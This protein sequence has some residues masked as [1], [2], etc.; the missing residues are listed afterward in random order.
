LAT[1]KRDIDKGE[2]SGPSE[3]RGKPAG[4][5]YFLVIAIDTYQFG[6]SNQ[7]ERTKS[8]VANLNNPVR[9]ASRI[10]DVLTGEYTFNPSDKNEGVAVTDLRKTDTQYANEK[11]PIP[12]YKDDDYRRTCLYNGEATAQEVIDMIGKISGKIGK[13][14]ALLIY[15]AGHGVRVKDDNEYYLLCADSD[16][17]RSITWLNV[18]RLYSAFNNYSNQNRCRDLLMVIDACFSGAST[19]GFSNA[20]DMNV[21]RLVW[22]STLKDQLADDGPP[23]HGSGFANAFESYLRENSSPFLKV[24]N[25][26]DQLQSK[27]DAS[28]EKLDD[29]ETFWGFLPGEYGDGFFVFERRE[30]GKPKPKDLKD[31]FIDYLNFDAHRYSLTRRYKD[32][33]NCLNIITTHGYSYDIQKVASKITFRWLKKAADMKFEPE[34]C[35]RLDRLTLDNNPDDLWS[36]LYR[37]L[38]EQNDTLLNTKES[39]HNYL[40]DRLLPEEDQY[41]GK[42]HAIMWFYFSRGGEE[43]AKRIRTFCDEFSTLFLSKW[44][45]LA[46]ENKKNLGKMFILFLD[47]RKGVNPLKYEDFEELQN[48]KKINLITTDSFENITSNDVKIWQQK[49]AEENKST[50]IQNL[51]DFNNVMKMMSKDCRDFE[52]TY[53]EFIEKLCIYCEYTNTEKEL[54]IEYLF[55]FKTSLI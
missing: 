16:P 46:E 14:D 42:K 32:A 51:T 17:T 50:K 52:C 18:N 45:R 19:F 43:N 36:I 9:D 27:F 25:I 24:R 41:Y 3:T 40:F 23:E 12:V 10:V 44:E 30:K 11:I 5:Y 39:I 1:T 28:P 13:E 47:E 31:S 53:E 37:Q 2:D 4:N 26:P 22:S 54:L 15:F 29:Q 38:K 34:V 7:L 55:D 21:S 33:R 48:I 35:F 6:Y 49:A 8:K 20:K